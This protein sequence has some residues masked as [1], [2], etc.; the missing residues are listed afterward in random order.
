[1]LGILSNAFQVAARTDRMTQSDMP[2][3]TEEVLPTHWRQGDRRRFSR[4]HSGVAE[5]ERDGPK[6]RSR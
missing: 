1:M 3:S 2:R 5:G 4:D 6:L